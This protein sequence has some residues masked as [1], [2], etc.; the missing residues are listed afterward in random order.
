[1][2]LGDFL[3]AQRRPTDAWN[4]STMTADWCMALGYPDFAA[5]WRGTVEPTLCDKVADDAGGL[6][7]LW[8]AGI[9]NSLR[10]VGDEPDAGDIAVIEAMGSQAGAIF[11]GDRWAIRGARVLHFLAP[12]QV[13]V[14]KA[15]RP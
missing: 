12:E 1:M 13:S 5:D 8:D 11:T 9:G 4:C 14:I 3:Q 6:V 15:W 10:V 7:V 2:T